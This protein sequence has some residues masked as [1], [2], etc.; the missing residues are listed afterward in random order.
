MASLTKR[1][2]SRISPNLQ[3]MLND[4]EGNGNA[5]ALRGDRIQK[6]GKD[7]WMK[8]AGLFEKYPCEE[9]D[10]DDQEYDNT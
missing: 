3:S 2:S 6:T 9:A 1:E 7:G 8:M 4:V 10:G 5:L